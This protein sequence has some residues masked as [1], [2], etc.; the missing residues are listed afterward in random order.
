MNSYSGIK[1]CPFSE[2]N[3]GLN[4]YGCPS[5]MRTDAFPFPYHRFLLCNMI[6]PLQCTWMMISLGRINDRD[7]NHFCFREKFILL[8]KTTVLQRR[9]CQ[10]KRP[11][12]FCERCLRLADKTQPQESKTAFKNDRPSVHAGGNSDE[13]PGRTINI[14][15]I[16]NHCRMSLFANFGVTPLAEVLRPSSRPRVNVYTSFAFHI[17]F[18]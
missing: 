9:K 8:S 15:K 17:I 13:I 7:T 2:T 14:T 18:S 12:F 10:L 1:E 16:T 5:G 11:S 3:Q 4:G 6:C